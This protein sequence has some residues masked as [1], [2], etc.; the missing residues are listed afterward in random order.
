MEIIRAV[1]PVL[2]YG[3]QDDSNGINEG[4]VEFALFFVVKLFTESNYYV[5]SQHER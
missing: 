2:R 3:V 5:T 4:L 1:Y